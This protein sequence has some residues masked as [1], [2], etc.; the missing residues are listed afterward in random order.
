MLSRRNVRTQFG[1]C[2]ILAAKKKHSF[3]SELIY[4]TSTLIRDDFNASVNLHST[5]VVAQIEK[6]S[7]NMAY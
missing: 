5:D 2:E 4:I 7:F 1:D 6:Q 3:L